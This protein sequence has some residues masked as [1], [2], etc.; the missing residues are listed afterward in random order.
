MN[1]LLTQLSRLFQF[2]VAALKGTDADYT[3]GSINKAIAL[4]AIPMVMEMIMESLF[5]IVDVYFVAKVSVNAVATVGL[6]EAV[7]FIIYALAEGLSIAAAAIVARRV[8]EK[9]LKTAGDAA[10]QAIT[11]AL[12]IGLPLGV[13]GFLFSDNVLSLM[14]G[15]QD[16]INEGGKYAQIMYAGNISV[17]LLF[18][19]NGVF[20][21]AGDAATAMRS[22]WLANGINIILDPILIF[23]WWIFPEMGVAGA[24]VATTIGRSVG[25]I[26][27]LYLLLGKNAIVRIHVKN[28]VVKTQMIIELFKVSFGSVAQFLIDSASW[29]VLVRVISIF[30]PDAIAGY[31][32][33]IRIVIFS[34]LPSWGLSNAAATLVGQNLGAKKPERAVKSVWRAAWVNTIFLFL[35]S[36]V[37][38]LLADW[39]IGFFTPEPIVK[40]NAINALKI[41][42]GGY[43][44]FSIG[45]VLG[46]AFNGSGDTRTP[47]W[48]HLG[49]FWLLQIPLAYILAVPLKFEDEGVYISIAFS[50][51]LYAAIMIVLFNRGTWKKTIV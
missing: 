16:L 3:K 20:R 40:G 46:Q 50:H 13:I 47:M 14:G 2:S 12:L 41:I 31:T 44:F 17:I 6:T 5:A 22:L 23:G 28:M 49:V 29:I 11:V 9:N 10:F 32:I 51:A 8:G 24:A 4:L 15:S 21:G 26:Y 38:F 42:C 30:G 18:L 33:A 19:L 25:V 39:I 7:L 27:Q 34:I 1:K 35:V 45:M 48:V 37:F 36:V 43:I